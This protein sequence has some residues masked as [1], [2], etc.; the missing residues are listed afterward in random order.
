MMEARSFL[1]Q[2]HRNANGSHFEVRT[3]KYDSLG[4]QAVPHPSYGSLKKHSSRE[5][6]CQP[7]H[8][9]R[10][11]EGYLRMEETSL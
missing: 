2:A 7:G 5:S 9:L 4:R 10:M 11:T 1:R 3:R 8:Y 6:D